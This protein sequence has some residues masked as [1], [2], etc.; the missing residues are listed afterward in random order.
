MREDGLGEAL[1]GA[2]AEEVIEYIRS[3]A[4]P[5]TSDS[6]WADPN[7]AFGVCPGNEVRG[8]VWGDLLVLFSDD[9]PVASGRRH[10]LSYSYGPPFAFTPQPAGMRTPR[11]ITIGSTV[12]ELR[13]A[14]PE[15]IVNEGD[16]IFAA[17]FH[18]SDNLNGFLTGAAETD[19]VE[20]IIGGV[21]C[22][23]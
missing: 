23:E 8:L 7:S 22:G 13:A 18:V 10:F 9:S 19:T 14:Y 4:G 6:G 5:P 16:D 1:F 3:L 20:S 2:D 11:G 15:V 12:A 17:N 21:G